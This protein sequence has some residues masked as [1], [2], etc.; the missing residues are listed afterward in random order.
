M[1]HYVP[2]EFG[3]RLSGRDLARQPR[4]DAV[5]VPRPAAPVAVPASAEAADL[6]PAVERAQRGDED[7]FRLLYRAVQPRLL[8]YLRALVG[9]DAEDVASEAWLQIVRDLGSFRGDFDAFRAWTA[10]IARHRGMDHLRHQQR[11]PTAAAPVELLT[12]LPGGLDT[13]IDALDLVSTDAAIALIAR[14]PRDQAEAVLLRV[15]MGLDAKTAARV[16]G[17]RAGA[18]RTAA[19]RG[20]RRL[21]QYLGSDLDP[22]VTPPSTGHGQDGGADGGPVGGPG[23]TQTTAAALKDMR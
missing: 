4:V 20:L 3:A 2:V 9:D 18:V 15:V 16:V 5:P 21:A 10:T 11:R 7:A 12:D 19:Y 1:G 22:A 6:S 17:K 23:V 8:R 14:L 13:A